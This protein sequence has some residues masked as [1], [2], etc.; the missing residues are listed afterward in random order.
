[1]LLWKFL[2]SLER[3]QEEGFAVWVLDKFWV[4]IFWK[5]CESAS[6]VWNQSLGRL[7]LTSE[8]KAGFFVRQGTCIMHLKA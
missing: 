7:V 2:R 5:A 1:M 3:S 8:V 6:N 4:M